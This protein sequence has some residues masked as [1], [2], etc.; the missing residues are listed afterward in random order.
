MAKINELVE[1]VV[2]KET[3]AFQENVETKRAEAK[4]ALADKQ[5]VLQ[6][7]LVAEKAK[8]DERL[9]TRYQITN[10]SQTIA[11]RDLLLRE[12][13]TL[14]NKVFS[15]AED[16]LNNLSSEAFKAFVTD[17]L[18]QFKGQGDLTLKL[19]E[20]SQDL[21]DQV[22]LETVD[23]EAVNI[24]LSDETIA[25]KGG[26]ILEKAGIQYNF[27]SDTLIKDAKT[28]LTVEISKLFNQ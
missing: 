17:I 4:Q 28:R 12:K 1:Q 19:G 14:L 10:Q 21:L 25:N 24:Q 3:L 6:A 7:D 22:W 13:Q 2:K 9:N 27:L 11:H 5:Q 16:Q 8:V 23:V 18:S 15:L 20:H 26:F